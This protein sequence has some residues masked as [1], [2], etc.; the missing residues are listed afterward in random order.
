MWKV[1]G[2]LVLVAGCLAGCIYLGSVRLEEGRKA[3]AARAEK[4]KKWVEE[5]NKLI[6]DF[7]AEADTA[8]VLERLPKWMDMGD[9]RAYTVTAKGKKAIAYDRWLDVYVDPKEGDTVIVAEQVLD[10]GR[11]RLC[12]VR[13]VDK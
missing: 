12:F 2:I 13:K 1:I 5:N 6:K 10:N 8:I 9:D 11:S 3:E 7:L 4:Y